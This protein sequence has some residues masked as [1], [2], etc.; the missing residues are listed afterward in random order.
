MKRRDDGV[1]GPV[2]D[3]VELVEEGFAE[4]SIIAGQSS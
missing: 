3:R 4:D 1:R 2:E